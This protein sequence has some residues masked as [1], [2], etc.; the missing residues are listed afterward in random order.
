M[1]KFRIAATLLSTVFAFGTAPV[2][3][4]ACNVQNGAKVEVVYHLNYDDA[5]ERK[6]NIPAGSTAVDWNATR[7]G[8]KLKD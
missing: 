5:G 3:L 2:L 6:V 8:F 1:K 7:D 4:T